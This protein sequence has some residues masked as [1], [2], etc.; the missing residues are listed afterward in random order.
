MARRAALAPGGGKY[1]SIDDG[2]PRMASSDLALLTDLV[3]AGKIKPVIDRSYTGADR[4]G[5][6][7]TQE[8]E[9]RRYCQPR[10]YVSWQ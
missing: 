10:R 6:A 5:R 7:G 1:I 3:E 2:M 9:L 8:G 4:R